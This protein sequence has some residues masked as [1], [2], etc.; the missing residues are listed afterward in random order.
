MDHDSARPLRARVRWGNVGAAAAIALALLLALAWLRSAD[1]PP[2]VPPPIAQPEPF[3]PPMSGGV[4]SG[5]PAAAEADPPAASVGER[6]RRRGRSG[7]G[8]VVTRARR[9]QRVR[10]H[11][12]RSVP[13]PAV[14]VPRPD[15]RRLHP[16]RGAENVS[17]PEFAL[18]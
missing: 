4:P 18:E 5:A 14:I 10:R 3:D 8:A 17:H 7:S 1:A 11:R 9:A 6:G 16:R 2:A 13:R 12:A 15:D